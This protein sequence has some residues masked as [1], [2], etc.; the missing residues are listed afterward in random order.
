MRVPVVTPRVKQWRYLVTYG[1]WC[2]GFVVLEV[3]ASLARQ[4]QIVCGCRAFGSQGG[5]MLDRESLCGVRFLTQAI[6]ATPMRTF[7]DEESQ[8]LRNTT[9]SHAGLAEVLIVA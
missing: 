1:I 7:S 3:V 9:S 5:D 8:A 4:G 6:L 2:R